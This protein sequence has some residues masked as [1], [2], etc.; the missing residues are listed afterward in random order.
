MNLKQ[1]AFSA[2]RWT[3]TSA[4]LVTGLQ[5]LQT[6]ILARLLVPAD[7]GLMAVVGAVLAVL[8][9]LANFGLSRV[10]IHFDQLPDTILS[11]LYWINLTLSALMMLIVAGTASAVGRLYNSPELAPLLQV[12]SITFPLT[13]LG[14][15]FR[16][17]AEKKLHFDL[18]AHNEIAAAA[19]AFLVAIGVALGGGGVYALV[20]GILASASVSSLLAWLRLSCEHRPLRCLHIGETWPYLRFGGYLVGEEFANILTRQADTFIGGLVLGPTALGIYS[21]PRNLSLRIAFIINPIITRVGFPVMAR[22]KHDREKLGSIYL[23]TLRMTTSVNFPIYVALGLFANEVVA[24]LYG[25]QWQNASGYLRIFAAWGLIRSVGNPT[26]SLLYAV[27]HARRAFWWNLSLLVICV[28]LLWMG[29]QLGGLVGLA[30]TMVGLQVL[31]FVPSWRYLVRPCC[32]V[33]FAE[34]IA[35]VLLPLAL[36]LTGGILAY[37]AI[38]LGNITGILRL[39]VGG[40]VGGSVYILL[41]L[42]FNRPWTNAMRELIGQPLHLPFA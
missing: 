15:Q 19:V 10:I 34:F 18:L 28:P 6:I 23:Q 37:G 12:A 25:R 3:A 27:G 1:T 33:S 17:L 2:G 8:T 32:G 24:L 14:Q 40:C 29:A 11:S 5:M 35:I 26:G 31:I 20:A 41:S 4:A 22:V 7:F 30:W 13:A 42:V 16:A 38:W 9:L 21:V 36:A 39:I